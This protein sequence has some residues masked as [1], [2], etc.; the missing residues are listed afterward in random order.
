[1]MGG[2]NCRAPVL[3]VQVKYS[4]NVNPMIN[5]NGVQIFQDTNSLAVI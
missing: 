2:G 4:V 3:D 5:N 1:M